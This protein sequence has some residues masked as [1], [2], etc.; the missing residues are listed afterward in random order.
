[1]NWL[2]GIRLM[3]RHAG[4]Q[5]AKQGGSCGKYFATDRSNLSVPSEEH[6]A[7]YKCK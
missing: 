3:G 7:R 1:M 6:W 5:T 4:R 2:T